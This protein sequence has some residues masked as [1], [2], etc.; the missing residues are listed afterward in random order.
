[1]IDTANATDKC[2]F[3]DK[4]GLPLLLI[5]DALVPFDVAAPVSSDK[6]FGV[7]EKI[8]KY[9]RRV[10][11]NG[12]VNVYDEARKRW[13][14][15]YVTGDGY[16]FKMPL[17]AAV[18]P[19][20]PNKPFNCS[21]L[22]HRAVASCITVPD[23]TKATK[24]WIG[25][26]DVIWTNKVRERNEKLAYRQKHM[27]AIDVAAVLGGSQQAHCRPISQVSAVVAEYAMPSLKAIRSFNW[28]TFQFHS[29]E[30]MATRLLAE[31]E[32]LRPG[33][34]QIVTV[35]DPVGIVSE[36]A[37][38]LKRNADYFNAH[39]SRSRQLKLDMAIA[40]FESTVKDNA[41][42][43]AHAAAQR[44]NNQYDRMAG[45][46]ESTIKRYAELKEA[47]LDLSDAQRKKAGEEAW[48]KYAE[49]I[50]HKERQSW[51]TGYK[52][53]LAAYSKAWVDPLA[54]AHVEVMKSSALADYFET[55]FDETDVDSGEVYVNTVSMCVLATQDKP[56]CA[57]LYAEWIHG[58]FLNK[59]I[60]CCAR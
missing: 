8:A 11:R 31:C 34:A 59:K 13:E 15:Y 42:L 20:K 14:A 9:T 47:A 5:R 6:P 60:S 52:K 45:V 54:T 18:I 48:E 36:L 22:G 30:T 4:R 53:N 40:G 55:N 58:A 1:M 23:P 2:E 49:K 26:S 29:R 24:V 56:A 27:V 38:L 41:V 25:F 35:P 19:I 50:N 43:K 17:K 39:P 51:Q 16:Y 21:N 10:L 57:K 37:L 32:A 12:F 28:N 7:P 33:K 46:S 44:S 3:C